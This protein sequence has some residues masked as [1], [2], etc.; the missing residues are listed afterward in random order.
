MRKLRPRRDKDLALG[1]A[2]G[3]LQSQLSNPELM[4][5]YTVSCVLPESTAENS[6]NPWA[7]I[8]IVQLCTEQF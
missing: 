3:K 4:G 2:N 6:C 7:D 8:S 1:Y 5:Q